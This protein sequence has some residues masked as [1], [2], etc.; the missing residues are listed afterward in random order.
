MSIDTLNL[1]YTSPYNPDVTTTPVLD[2]LAREGVRFERAYTHVPVT[3]PSHAALMT[4]RSPLDLGVLAN[5]DDVP[6]SARTLAE[7]LGEASYE[8]AAFVSLGVLGHQ[9]HLDQGFDLYHDPFDETSTRWYRTADE[10]F[11][12]VETWVEANRDQ[13]FFLWVHFSDPHEPYLPVDAPPDGELYVDDAL[14]G[15]YRLVSAERYTETLSLTPGAHRLR[16]VSLRAPRPDD[17]PETAITLTFH[18]PEDPQAGS[19]DASLPLDE[20]LRLA[21]SFETELVNPD[22][23]TREA[24]LV[25]SGGLERP[26]PEDVLPSYEAEVA[27]TDRFLGKLEELLRSLDPPGDDGTLLVV[28]S[29]HGEGLFHHDLLGHAKDVYEDQLRILW[30]LRGPGIPA[31]RV[32]E[33]PVALITDVAPTIL[34]LLGLDSGKGGPGHA[35]APSEGGPMEGRS[36]KSCFDG[37]AC[38]PEAPFWAYAIDHESRRPEAM[39]GYVWPYKWMWQRSEGRTGYD[40]SADPREETDLLAEGG[41]NHPESLKR[42]AESFAAERR[43][44]AQSSSRGGRA[45]ESKKTDELLRSLGYL[46]GRKQK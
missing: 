19:F 9:F 30:L 3:L 6:S 39:A 5:G 14:V 33:R 28:V 40:L 10:V 32:I 42:L 22:D 1:R 36:W 37:V 16:F 11:G 27:Y 15:R 24:L 31:G 44:L 18:P 38:P 46:G 34:D 17:R 8:T 13:R 43:K 25:F 4:G 21:P 20:P 26:T 41:P 35:E 23:T 7:I 12:P 29:D 2:R 45:G